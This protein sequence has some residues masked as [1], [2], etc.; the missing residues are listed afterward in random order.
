MGNLMNGDFNKELL[1]RIAESED[2][3]LIFDT[4][5]FAFN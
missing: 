2:F 3:I 4:N 1:K 5:E